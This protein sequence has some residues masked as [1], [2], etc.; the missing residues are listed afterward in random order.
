MPRLRAPRRRVLLA[1]LPAV[2]L[3]GLALWLVADPVQ[4]TRI[5]SYDEIEPPPPRE[6][7]R[8]GEVRLAGWEARTRSGAS[9]LD[10]R[11]LADRFEAACTA[12]IERALESLGGAPLD[13]PS[14]ITRRWDDEDESF[15]ACLSPG[16]A[17]ALHRTLHARRAG[18]RTRWT[19]V[20]SA[21]LPRPEALDAERHGADLPGVPPP[22]G[23]RRIA[24]SE[25]DGER[26]AIYEVPPGTDARAGLRA[27]GWDVS[28]PRRHDGARVSL[29]QR[30]PRV[31][32]VVED[33]DRVTYLESLGGS[34]T[35]P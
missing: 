29:A 4:A 21:E 10:P 32:F 15:V 26:S 8:S 25:R 12:P 27:A 11:A 22:A 7:P 18:G 24:S 6:A 13:A 17:E 16:D 23:A 3:Y 30:G 9:P 5:A 19:A 1:V 31:V 20:W 2:A 33:G 34:R 35:V 28:A 14:A